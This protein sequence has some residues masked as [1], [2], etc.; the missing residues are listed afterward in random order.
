MGAF[1]S[2]G[3]VIFRWRGHGP[4]SYLGGAHPSV[5]RVTALPYSW[6]MTTPDL[7]RSSPPQGAST[8][9]DVDSVDWPEVM[10][11]ANAQREE[12]LSVLHAMLLRVARADAWRR[13][14]QLNFA[15]PELDDIAHQAADDAL[16][17]ICAKLGQFRG[18][19][20]FST[21]AYKFAVLEVGIKMNRHF[22]RGQSVSLDETAWEQMPARFGLQPEQQAIG[23]QLLDGVRAAIE[24][25]LSPKQRQIFL[26]IVVTGV[27]LD[28]LADELGSNR[29]AIYKVMFDARRKI[30]AALVADG[31]IL[32][33]ERTGP[34]TKAQS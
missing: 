21:W 23:R 6:A 3:S 5:T 32:D 12:A 31:L 17:A 16:V 24:T 30:R 13:S 29:N 4:V 10:G 14:H 33:N 22:W 9:G 1:R 18:E 2:A 7:S 34:R 19:S 26:A 15:G 11:E 28:V 27:P 25:Q 20:R 8:P